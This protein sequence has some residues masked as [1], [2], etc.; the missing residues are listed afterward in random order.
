VSNFG[1]GHPLPRLSNS[2]FAYVDV[3]VSQEIPYP[4][5]LHFRRQFV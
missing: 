5:K 2:D 1:V 3:G 4:G